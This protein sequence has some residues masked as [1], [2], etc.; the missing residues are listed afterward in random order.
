MAHLILSE[1]VASISELKK[2]PMK[3]FESG[4]GS[5]IAI[6]NRNEPVFYCVSPKMLESL[7]EVIEDK[8]WAEIVK[9]R[10]NDEMIEVDPSELIPRA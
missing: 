9:S 4:Y 6:L 8:K 7:F 5:P 10:E 1:L 2:H 3:V